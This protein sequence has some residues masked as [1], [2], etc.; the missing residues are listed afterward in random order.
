MSTRPSRRFCSY[1]IE[2]K[3]SRMMICSLCMKVSTTGRYDS[4]RPLNSWVSQR[5][6]LF[7][8]SIRFATS[9]D[10]PSSF[11]RRL[12]IGAIVLRGVRGDECA[13]MVARLSRTRPRSCM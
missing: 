13:I 2:N 6:F 9:D 10:G 12:A 3:S 1:A 11:S 8:L 7:R 4:S 5:R